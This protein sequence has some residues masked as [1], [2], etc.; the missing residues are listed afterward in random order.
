MAGNQEVLHHHHPHLHPRDRSRLL[1]TFR[2]LDQDLNSLQFHQ[3]T[4]SPMK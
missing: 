3:T 1:R 4:I 2:P